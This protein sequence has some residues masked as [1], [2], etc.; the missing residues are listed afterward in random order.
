[1]PALYTVL[2]RQV[3][4][5]RGRGQLVDSAK[6]VPAWLPQWHGHVQQMADD[7]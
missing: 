2:L 7:S 3:P 5:L 4:L 1:M 6:A